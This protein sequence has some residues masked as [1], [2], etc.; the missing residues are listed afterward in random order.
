[1]ATKK[2]NKRKYKS[3]NIAPNGN[4]TGRA[5]RSTNN[6]MISVIKRMLAAQESYYGK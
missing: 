1:M 4:I 5:L 2:Q 3:I 6:K